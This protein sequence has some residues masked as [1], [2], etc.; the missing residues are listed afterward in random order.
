MSPV[1][2]S[3]RI[4]AVLI[5]ALGVVSTASAGPPLICHTFVTDAGAR[6]LPWAA[7]RDWHAPDPSYDAAGLIEDT[8][9]L[10]SADA[11]I[12]E[13][14]ENLRRATIYAA[15]Q[16]G[17]TAESLLRAVLERTDDGAGRDARG[18]PRVV[19]RGLSR[20]GVPAVRAHLRLPHAVGQ[21]PA[22]ADA[23]DGAC[24]PRWLRAR[25]ERRW[26]WRRTF[27]RSSTSQP[28]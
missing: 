6:L 22:S 15:E 20:R 9:G 16:P 8:L 3:S 14:M 1:F 25:A 7:S 21:R 27:M 17:G 18:S 12:L 2:R 4:A 24:G 28:R 11:P 23:D 5:A 26:Q 10:L 19:R 13:R